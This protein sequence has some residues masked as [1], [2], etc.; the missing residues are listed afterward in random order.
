VSELPGSGTPEEL[1]SAAGIDAP[2]I[3]AAAAE[4]VE[5]TRATI[6]AE[7]GALEARANARRPR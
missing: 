5:E 1:L 4:L 7:D 2:H 3:A 6:T